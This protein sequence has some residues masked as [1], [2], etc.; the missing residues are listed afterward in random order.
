MSI[1]PTSVNK[2]DDK[3]LSISWSNRQDTHYDVVDL[4]R[5]CTCAHCIDE[6]TGEQRLKPEHVSD[7][8]RPVHI[9]SLGRYAISVDWTDGHTSSIYSWE[10]LKKLA[11]LA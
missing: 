5:A 8:V 1:T 4:R 6:I 10:R 7:T 3:T 11:D 2:K 9:R